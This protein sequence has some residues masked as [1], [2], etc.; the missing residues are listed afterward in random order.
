MYKAAF[1]NGI[2]NS[3][4]KQY[5]LPPNLK[6]NDV[7]IIQP[8]KVQGVKSSETDS[9]NEGVATDI[10]IANDIYDEVNEEENNEDLKEEPITDDYVYDQPIED[11]LSGDLEYVTRQE[12]IIENADSIDSKNMNYVRQERIAEQQSNRKISKYGASFRNWITQFLAG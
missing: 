1:P 2:L 7:V 3:I 9:D 10:A 12:D 8:D 6:G 11:R 4:R 5:S